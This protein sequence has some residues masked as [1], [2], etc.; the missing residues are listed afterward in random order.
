MCN[1][2]LFMV[3]VLGSGFDRLGLERHVLFDAQRLEERLDAARPEHLR[4]RARES[5]RARMRERAN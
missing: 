3:W 4:G 2:N 5:E 1:F